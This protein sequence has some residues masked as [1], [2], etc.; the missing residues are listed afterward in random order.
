MLKLFSGNSAEILQIPAAIHFL[1]DLPI[2]SS[3]GHKKH[4]F[5]ILRDEPEV[6]GILDSHISHVALAT[7]AALA[8]GAEAFIIRTHAKA[9]AIEK[10][11]LLWDLLWGISDFI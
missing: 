10:G 4:K 9:E 5:I 6:S 3:K 7:G 11:L 2:N 8:V 1:E